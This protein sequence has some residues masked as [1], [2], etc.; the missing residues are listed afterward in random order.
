MNL[1]DKLKEKENE[2]QK[3]YDIL[4]WRPNENE[5][6]EGTVVE[7]GETITENGDAEYLQ[8]ETGNGETGTGKF[9]IFIN[10]VLRQMIVAED[11]KVGDHIAIKFLGLVQSKKTKRKYKDYV[12]VKDEERGT[13]ESET[14]GA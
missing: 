9:M 5:V 2:R 13:A 3:G 12:L 8:M 1:M 7:M 10:S 6:I 4:F 11:V 14:A